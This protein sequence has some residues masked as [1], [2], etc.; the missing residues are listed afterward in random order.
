MFLYK[1]SNLTQLSSKP[2][3]PCL[4]VLL[5]AHPFIPHPHTPTLSP[6]ICL[7]YDICESLSCVTHG[8]ESIFSSHEKIHITPP[9]DFLLAMTSV[10]LHVYVHVCVYSY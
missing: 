7:Y 9:I 5:L 6:H 4:H 1:V 10:C 2:E 3:S 8:Q